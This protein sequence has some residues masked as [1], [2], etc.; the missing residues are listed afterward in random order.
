MF[1]MDVIY[2]D[3]NATTPTRPEVVEAM[4][5]CY[6]EGYANPASWHRAGQ[7]ARRVIEDAREK[8]AAIL[9]ADLGPPRRDRLVFTSGGTEA[10]NLAI[11]GIARAAKGTVPFSLERDPFSL[12]RESGQSPPGRIVV[13]AGEHPSVLGPAEHLLDHGWRL[14]TLGLTPRGVVRVEQ[15]P[16]LLEAGDVRLVSV[17]L[18]NHETGVLQPVAELAALCRRAG[19]SMHT[20]AVGVVGKLPVSFRALD[21]DGMSVAAHKFRGPL[22]IGALLL[23]GDVAIEPLAFG[24]HQ[25]AGLRPGTESVALAVGMAV[26]LELWQQEQ[27]AVARHLR[28]MRDRL[29]SGLLAAVPGLVVHGVEGEGDSP[30]FVDTVKGTVPFSLTRKLGQ[31]PVGTKIGTVLRLPQTSNMAFPGLDGETL[32]MALDLAGVA[33][34]V[35]AACSSGSAELSPTLR[36]MGLGSPL[37]A[38]SLR[39][40]V[41][42]TTTAD[43]V[44]E[45]VR[46]I[47][48]VSREL[49]AA[50]ETGTFFGPQRA[51]K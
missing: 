32:W 23:R 15:L 17:Q 6:A 30:I 38:S 13:S 49:Q 46:R 34:S 3:H 39:L 2:L 27:D 22:G 24:G 25:Q 9:D 16:P 14:D 29:E 40:S 50:R 37:V 36:A 47:A 4:N 8:I 35:G 33:C 10:N 45:A 31:S 48:D 44:D 18:G 41:G 7:R 26:A 43:E 20:D 19:V 12:E 42:A 21:V 51:E 28:A 11:L 5:R 1:C